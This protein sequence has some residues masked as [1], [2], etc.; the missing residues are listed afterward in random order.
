MLM[1]SYMAVQARSLP[2]D[3]L[4]PAYYFINGFIYITQVKGK[5][6][7]PY[8]ANLGLKENDQGLFCMLLLT[9]HCVVMTGV[10]LDIHNIKWKSCCGGSWKTLLFRL[11]IPITSN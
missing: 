2:I 6:L 9:I 4:R 7:T 5:N 3:K 10:H 1:D 8:E 11:I